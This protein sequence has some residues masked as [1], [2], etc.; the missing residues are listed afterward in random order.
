VNGI[1]LLET[2]PTVTTTVPVVAPPGTSTT[3]LL[4]PQLVVAVVAVPLN[5]T[6]LVP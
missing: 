2:P 3:R 1:P 6:V 4:A 5:R